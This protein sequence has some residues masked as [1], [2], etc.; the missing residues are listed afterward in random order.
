[1]TPEGN[2]NV[3]QPPPAVQREPDYPATLAKPAKPEYRRHLPHYQEG[4]GP[5]FVTFI[6]AG[7]WVLPESLRHMDAYP[8][9]WR[10][11][12]EGVPAT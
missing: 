5:I 7:R 4:D 1:M 11:W 9:L 6:T 8:W 2:K 3:G 10:E 12:V